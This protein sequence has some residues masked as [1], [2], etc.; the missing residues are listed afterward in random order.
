MLL[1]LATFSRLRG[2]VDAIIWKG[3]ERMQA[4]ILHMSKFLASWMA[5]N[6]YS[7]THTE[8]HKLEIFTFI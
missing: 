1:Q 3:K 2:F 6:H 7:G 8:H 4:G 5:N